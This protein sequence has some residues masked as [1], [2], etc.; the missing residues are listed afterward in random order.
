M[1]LSITIPYNGRYIEYT[2][3]FLHELSQNEHFFKYL[4][5]L[6]CKDFQGFQ[7]FDEILTQ[8]LTQCSKLVSFSFPIGRQAN[9]YSSADEIYKECEQNNV[10]RHL[11]NMNHLRILNVS[12]YGFKSFVELFSLPKS[13]QKLVLNVRHSF[14]DLTLIDLLKKSKLKRFKK[15]DQIEI[16]KIKLPRI[17]ESSQLLQ[18]FVVPLLQMTP[19]LRKF[20]LKLRTSPAYRAKCKPIDLSELLGN[21]DNLKQL[22]SIKISNYP[23]KFSASSKTESLIQFDPKKSLVILSKLTKIGLYSEFFG[24]FDFKSLVKLFSSVG[25]A[26]KKIKLATLSLD[27]FNIFCDYVKLVNN[28][29]KARRVGFDLE[30]TLSVKSLEELLGT[31]TQPLIL[32]RNVEIKLN[33]YL[34]SQSEEQRLSISGQLKEQFWRIFCDFELNMTQVVLNPSFYSSNFYDTSVVIYHHQPRIFPSFLKT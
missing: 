2:R 25:E 15:L 33:I 19:N 27:S 10:L 1:E 32:E 6:D 24:D 14:Y 20:R 34:I 22:E 30:I 3:N 13:L 18:K 11:E 21:M 29:A 17:L 4:T 26:K 16:L 8:I 9:Y 12:V 5:H 31:F 28:T 23:S 7:Y